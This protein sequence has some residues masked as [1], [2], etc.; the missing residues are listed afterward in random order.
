[1]VLPFSF[2][3]LRVLLHVSYIAVFMPCADV[4]RKVVAP[5]WSVMPGDLFFRELGTLLAV[6]EK[7]SV[8]WWHDHPPP[9]RNVV[10]SPV[11]PVCLSLCPVAQ[12]PKGATEILESKF[13]PLSSLVTVE[14][15]PQPMEL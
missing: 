9:P 5:F 14:D 8:F 15:A 10:L 12:V 7:S 13:Q 2:G 3:P 11:T 1:M 4:S 6:P